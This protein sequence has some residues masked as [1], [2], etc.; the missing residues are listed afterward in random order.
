MKQSYAKKWVKA[1]RSGKYKQTQKKLKDET[2]YCCL[3][4]LCEVAGKKFTNRNGTYYVSRTD[5]SGTVPDVVKKQTELYSTIGLVK[6]GSIT[7][8]LS[9]FNDDRNWSFKKIATYIEK[10]WRNL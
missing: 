1:L 2:G 6:N 5:N 7:E 3:G 9:Q 8:S 4:V 10:N